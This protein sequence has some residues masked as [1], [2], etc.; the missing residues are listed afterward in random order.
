MVHVVVVSG[1]TTSIYL[2][3]LLAASAPLGTLPE[4]LNLGYLGFRGDL[5]LDQNFFGEGTEQR[6]KALLQSQCTKLLG[7]HYALLGPEYAQ[8]HP[9]VPPRTAPTPT[10]SDVFARAWCPTKAPIASESDVAS[11]PDAAP[12][13]STASATPI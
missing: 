7:P 6:Y 5:L 4:L 1:A 12:N 3:G 2:N 10:K 11:A 9:L 8:L 13:P